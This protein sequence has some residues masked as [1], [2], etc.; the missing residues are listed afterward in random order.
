MK[1]QAES[2][3]GKS[4]EQGRVGLFLESIKFSHSIFALPFALS[5]FFMAGTG[6][7]AWPLLG[8]V[9]AACVFARTAAMSFNRLID[10]RI[11]ARN[12]RTSSRAVPA[13]DLS[14]SFMAVATIGSCCLFGLCC[15]WINT[16]ALALC[17][18]ALGILLGYSYTK[19]F[20]SLSHLVLGV[21]LGLSP[22]GAWVA[23]RAEIDLLPVLL[24]LAV[25]FWTAGFDVIYACQ[26]HGFDQEEGLHSLP[27]K[28]GPGR[29][30]ALSKLFHLLAITLLGA[31]GC[32][33]EFGLYYWAGVG[34]VAGL[35]V[36]E[37][38]LV[39][40]GDLSKVNL[41]FFTLNGVVSL[42][43]MTSVILEVVVS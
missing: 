38:S 17:P 11:D 13:G 36:Y 30:L 23:V 14:P 19:R 16:L 22:V 7:L 27:V 41:A 29:A 12:P 5:A 35:L 40:P 6:S 43:F 42:V 2:D 18:V 28:V 15:A 24:G 33:A 9:V 37:Q 4:R 20:T 32:I 10:A 34:L 3:T 26:D 39:K 21:A 31:V 1:E 25:A 8:K